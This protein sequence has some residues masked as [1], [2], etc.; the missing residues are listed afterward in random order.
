M[1]NTKEKRQVIKLVGITA[2]TNNQ[3]EI[4]GVNAK[5]GPCIQHYYQNGLFN[6]IP[7]RKNPGTTFCCY[8]DYASDYKGDYT[9]FI[10]EEVSELDAELPEGFQKLVIDPQT[11][12]KFTTEKGQM[13]NI[14]ID[15]WQTIWSQ[16]EEG[17][18]EGKRS[19]KTDFE[20]YD[21]RAQNPAEATVDIYIGIHD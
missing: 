3:N 4:S 8:T 20:L 17:S 18:L 16:E 1:N 15:A 14:V 12:S 21:A 5:I 6:H 13:P 10:G 2:R 9:Y 19:Y 7:N 11:Y